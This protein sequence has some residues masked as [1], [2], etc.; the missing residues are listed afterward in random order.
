MISSQIGWSQESK[1]LWE[2]LKKVDRLNGITAANGGGGNPNDPTNI[3]FA[4]S[5]AQ[6]AFGRLR[7]SAPYTLFDSSHRFDDNDL[8]S[9]ATATGGTSVFNTNQGLVD[10]NVTAASGS[11][12]VRETIKVFAYQPGKSLLIMNT[13][14]MAA[15]KTGLTQRV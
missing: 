14:V 7:M 10:L 13:F 5:T 6:D 12:V 3:V 8:W 11:S 1:L 15:P 9:T 2:L 4:P